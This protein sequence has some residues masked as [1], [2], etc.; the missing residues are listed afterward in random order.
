MS[1]VAGGDRI[2]NEHV[3]STAKSYIDTVLSSFPGFVSAD[4]TGGVAAGKSDHGDID[5]IVHIEGTD[6]KAIKKELQNYLENQSANKILPFRSDKYAGRR[7]YNAGEL[8]SVLFPQTEA[9]KT[10]QIDNIVA[11]TKDESAF[12][13][14]FLDW[15]AEKQGLILGLIKTAIQEANATKTIDRLFASIGLGAPKTNRVLEFNLSGIELQLR[16]YEKDHRGR[17]AKGTREVLWKSNNWNDVVSLLRNYDLTKSFDDLL[18]DVQASL[19][20]PTSKDRVKGVFNAMVSIKSGEVG[21][22]KADR[23]QETINM[24]NAMESKHILFR[25]LMEC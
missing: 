14:S 6:K 8:V 20:H 12:K 17:E 2:S 25:S 23:K 21:T 24:V 22:P 7:S 13:K 10:A 11:V 5:L 15:P 4:V 18:P 9:G 1:G 3:N 19:K 16:A